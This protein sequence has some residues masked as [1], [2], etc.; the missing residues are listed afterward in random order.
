MKYIDIQKL[1]N[2][3]IY[4]PHGFMLPSI[5]LDKN[6]RKEWPWI[7]IILLI[8]TKSFGVRFYYKNK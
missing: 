3:P 4:K 7:A 1:I 8:G 2:T 6:I 5:L